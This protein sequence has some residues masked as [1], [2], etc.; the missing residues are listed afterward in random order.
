MDMSSILST[1]DAVRT[2]RREKKYN[3]AALADREY[4]RDRADDELEYRRGIDA[5]DRARSLAD[6]DRARA[7]ED[8]IRADR[9]NAWNSGGKNLGA[10]PGLDPQ[11]AASIRSYFEGLAKEGKAEEIQRAQDNTEAL[12]RMLAWVK[13]S[14]DPA[15]AYA[16]MRQNL[17]AEMQ[18]DVPEA[19]DPRA[20]DMALAKTMSVA[21][22]MEQATAAK[23]DASF[24]G[25]FDQ[26][27]Q[28]QG[29]PAPEQAGGVNPQ[30]QAALERLQG[31][32]G[33]LRVISSYRDPEHNA[34]VGGAKG[35]Q[36]IH[37]NA[38]DIDTTGMDDSQRAQLI[39]RAREAGFHGIGVYKGSLHFDI[40]PE[41]AWG[42]DYHRGSLPEW[43]AGPATNW[44]GQPPQAAAEAAPAPA[45]PQAGPPPGGLD[46]RIVALM[47]AAGQQQDA[48]RRDILTKAIDILNEQSQGLTPD[49]RYR[50]QG[51]NLIDLAAP[52][53]PQPVKMELPPP[54]PDFGAEDDLRKEFIGSHV[55]K[56]FQVQADA[57]G[58]IAAAAK[59]PSAAG[60][61]ALIF[62]FMK[63]L[64]PGSV[65]REQEFANAQ[66]AA[67]VP[68]QIRNA[69]NRALTGERLAPAQR[70]DFLRQAAAIYGSAQEQYKAVESQ[71]RTIAEQSG[72]DV[73]RSVPSFGYQGQLP[74]PGPLADNGQGPVGG[75][76]RPRA[77]NAQGQMIEYDG[78]QWVP[79]SQ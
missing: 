68:D 61:L 75:A 21:D 42:P 4:L 54:G 62:S 79:V 71:Y 13:T 69:W 23:Q 36:H 70:D 3:D 73:T 17:P 59:D 43:A 67:G 28:P 45:A 72:R 47:Q 40:G 77:T 22:I 64:D 31:A 10:L 38:F 48:G 26:L 11:G 51:D 25:V 24:N 16:M 34:K 52:G 60:D 53:G 57:A 37:G 2:A 7:E 78:A 29:A 63:I 76:V 12:G 5:E 55:V 33:P 19:Y 58:R 14:P 6:E 32:T 9:T 56:N 66:N 74:Q 65:V 30:A 50:T 41:R 8:R 27:K 35:S 15:A 46:P 20:V 1:V 39:A 44:G 49:K 18:G